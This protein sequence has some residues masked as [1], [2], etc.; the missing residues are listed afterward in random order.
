MSSGMSS[1]P[2]LRS[3]PRL[4]MKRITV[5]ATTTIGRDSTRRIDIEYRSARISR[6]R[7]KRSSSGFKIAAIRRPTVLAPPTTILR[8]PVVTKK[9]ADPSHRIGAAARRFSVAASAAVS[10]LN[11]REA[12][13]GIRVRATTSETRSEKATVN[14][15][16]R[17]SWAATPSTKT[18]GTKTQMVVMVEAVI[19][20]PT[21]EVPA[22]AAS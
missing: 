13:I 1:E 3:K 5:T 2:R 4:A 20:R 8:K 6:A 18:I 10:G 22:S 16:S 15:W 7:S 14:A 17:K 9:T 21:S 11:S 12:S 19:A